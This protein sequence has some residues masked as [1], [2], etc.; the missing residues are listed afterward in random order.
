MRP[1]QT[2]LIGPSK[3]PVK[4]PL[5]ATDTFNFFEGRPKGYAGY[6]DYTAMN[7]CVNDDLMARPTIE[8]YAMLGFGVGMLEGI[9]RRLAAVSNIHRPA[10][11]IPDASPKEQHFLG[12]LACLQKAGIDNAGPSTENLRSVIQSV[13]A[14]VL[15]NGPVTMTFWDKVQN[16]KTESLETSAT[17][18]ADLQKLLD[19]YQSWLREGER[20]AAIA[21]IA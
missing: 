13:A 1:D 6:T 7:V 3:L 4:L 19:E 2:S 11:R 15:Q 18:A 21:I 20:L 12:W 8:Q 5:N 16:N 17:S 14:S 9:S 10:F